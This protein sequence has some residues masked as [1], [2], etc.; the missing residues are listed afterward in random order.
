MCIAGAAQMAAGAISTGGMMAMAVRKFH[1]KVR[2]NGI[3]GRN[4][5][6]THHDKSNRTSENRFTR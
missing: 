2:A 4:H 1:T 6:R 5:R 3:P